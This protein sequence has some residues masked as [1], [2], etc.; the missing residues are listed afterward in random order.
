M[1]KFLSQGVIGAL[2][3]S[4]SALA[5][6]FNSSYLPNGP[7]IFT[8]NVELS[9]KATARNQHLIAKLKPLVSQYQPPWFYI[10]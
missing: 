10:H 3:L 9:A 1:S 8:N 5:F 7:H 6:M 2:T 4:T